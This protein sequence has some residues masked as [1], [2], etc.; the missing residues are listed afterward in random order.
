M[1]RTNHN[2]KRNPILPSFAIVKSIFNHPST[3]EKAFEEHN[4]NH[5]ILGFF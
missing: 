1:R 5:L 2:K 4:I 3:T